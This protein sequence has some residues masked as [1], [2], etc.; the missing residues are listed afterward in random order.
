MKQAILNFSTPYVSCIN[1]IKTIQN[2][3]AKQFN[4]RLH[5]FELMDYFQYDLAQ[6]TI[7][8]KVNML[9]ESQDI[10]FLA[11]QLMDVLAI[12]DI[13][14]EM[15]FIQQSPYSN[16]HYYAA[17]LGLLAALFWIVTS[18]GFWILA[19]GM[20]AFAVV[21]SVGLLSWMSSSFFKHAWMQAKLGWNDRTKPFFNMDSLFVST[22]LLIICSSIFNLFFPWLPNLLEAGFLIFGF[23][24]LGIIFQSYLDKKMGFSRSLVEM[25][26]YRKYQLYSNKDMIYAKDLEIRQRFSIQKGDIVPVD[27]QL[28][29]YS[30]DFEIRDM[31]ETGS[32]QSLSVAKMKFFLAGAECIAG[33]AVFEVS[34]VLQ[35][36]RFARMDQSIASLVQS[37][38]KSPI[39]NRLDDWLQWFI[40]GIFLISMTSFLVVSQFFPIA[41][42]FTCALSVLVSACPCTLGLIVPMA[43]R[44]GAYKS[45]AEQIFFQTSEA[46]QKAAR[47]DIMVFDYHGTLTQGDWQISAFQCSPLFSEQKALQVIYTIESQIHA[48]PLGKKIIES[49]QKQQAHPILS[50]QVT[51]L[52][53]G[54]MLMT[55]EGSWWFGNGQILEHL[56]IQNKDEASHRL[57]LLFQPKAGEPIVQVGFF[58]VHDPLKKDAKKLIDQMRAKGTDVRIC[59]GADESTAS[60]ISEQLGMD[61]AFVSYNNRMDDKM[62]F[63]KSL[64]QEFPHQ[65]L[66]MVGDAINDKEAL[67]ACD[68]SIFMTNEHNQNYLNTHL[69]NSVDILVVSD[70]LINMGH[71]FQIAHDTISVIQQ[72]LFLSMMYNVLS[73]ILAAGVF[74]AWGFSLPPVMGVI[75]MMTQSAFLLLNTY[76]VIFKPDD[77]GEMNYPSFHRNARTA[78]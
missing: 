8:L 18:T 75:L 48:H 57:Y 2:H 26:Q 62:K 68:L 10:A 13:G 20:Q 51:D 76:R 45:S 67:N 21:S 1:C 53:F 58:D 63:L 9:D 44:M 70:A 19:P 15:I 7:Q 43:L 65:T 34:Q 41:T 17:L 60:M 32:Y 55:D 31:L 69:K 72:N 29:T 12:E 71:A 40:P 27:A 74:L 6:K 54:G 64:K 33:Q 42:A 37:Q 56:N 47:V 39:L 16:I 5:H 23:R 59:T 3:I 61:K 73:L 35:Q 66:A 24:H 52:D 25:F 11:Q 38:Q 14:Q 49:I 30:D 28:I 36:S 50:G 22:G 78:T 46:L 77:A 4:Q